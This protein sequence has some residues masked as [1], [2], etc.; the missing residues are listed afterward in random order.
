VDLVGIEPTTSSMPW[1]R[2]PSC[3]T[4]PLE[5]GSRHGGTQPFSRRESTIVKPTRLAVIACRLSVTIH[6]GGFWSLT[7]VVF[8]FFAAGFLVDFFAGSF[9]STTIFFGG[10]A[11]AAAAAR[12]ARSCNCA[13][14]LS[15]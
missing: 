7:V 14:S 11:A 6:F 1:K 9:S 8:F 10:A 5:E 15:R 12:R 4:G 3:A 2:A 13:T